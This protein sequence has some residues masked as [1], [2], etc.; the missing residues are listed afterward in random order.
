MHIN[1]IFLR[2]PNYE[3]INSFFFFY[4]QKP[5]MKPPQMGRLGAAEKLGCSAII[6][7]GITYYS[8]QSKRVEDRYECAH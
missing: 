5:E 1:I 6:L 4:Y 7:N 3:G 8:S 2:P